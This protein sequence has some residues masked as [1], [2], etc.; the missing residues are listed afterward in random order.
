MAAVSSSR[1]RCSTAAL[2]VFAR[3]AL[4]EARQATTPCH[5]RRSPHYGE[6]PTVGG[7]DGEGWLAIKDEGPDMGEAVEPE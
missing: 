5:A 7:V 2:R 1:R 3:G 4:C 6:L